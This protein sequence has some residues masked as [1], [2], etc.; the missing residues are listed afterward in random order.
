MSDED[1]DYGSG[2][3]E[4]TTGDE[5]ETNEHTEEHG[6]YE[7]IPK[8]AVPK[9]NL[10]RGALDSPGGERAQSPTSPAPAPNQS[11]AR[12]SYAGPG[13]RPATGTTSR[14]VELPQAPVLTDAQHASARK[15]LAAGIRKLKTKTVI[16]ESTPYDE[17]FTMNALSLA[18]LFNMG[19]GAYAGKKVGIAQTNEDARDEECQTEPVETRACGGQ[20]PE[21]RNGGEGGSTLAAETEDMPLTAATAIITQMEPGLEL[22]MNAFVMWAGPIVLAALGVAPNS[23]RVV[24]NSNPSDGGLSNGLLALVYSDLLANRPVSSVAFAAGAGA[25]PLLLAAYGPVGAQLG[26]EALLKD[27]S[28]ATK[29]LLCVWDLSAPAT[30]RAILVSEGSPTCCGFAPSPASHV[31]YAGMEEGGLCLW[32]LEEPASRHQEDF[33]GLVPIVC[34]RPSYTTEHLAEMNTSGSPIV[35]VITVPR[36]GSRNNPCYMYSLSAFG[37]VAVWTLSILGR[38]EASGGGG[39]AHDTDVDLGMRIGSSVRLIRLATNVRLGLSAL[40][41]LDPTE[42]IKGLDSTVQ[43]SAIQALPQNPRHFLVAGDAGRILKG[44]WAGLAPPPKELV[45]HDHLSAAV[46]DGTGRMR[47]PSRVT[48]LHVSPFCAWGVLSGHDDGTI[49]LHGVASAT[50]S[51]VWPAAV[52]GAV[53]A[54]RWSPARPCVFLV[55]DALCTVHVFDLVKSRS[56]P[57][58][59]QSFMAAGGAGGAASLA[60]CLE[61]GVLPQP[62]TSGGGH[63]QLPGFAVGYD[64]GRVDFMTFA[65]GLLSEKGSTA[66]EAR[67]LELIVGPPP[68]VLGPPSGQGSKAA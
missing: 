27:H 36:G 45:A 52:G 46:L 30:P 41:H 16:L 62:E 48:A 68:V 35:S 44:S 22:K 64:D 1:D 10:G 11:R 18:D 47:V 24:V 32:D 17:I 53:L 25:E 51:L 20:A 21:D 65:G 37:N 2:F 7:V 31:V 59:S 40:K 38:Q 9:S 50:A 23:K 5:L 55:L 12:N 14:M 49:A 43:S 56:A 8:A 66:E 61:V 4:Y 19:R 67:E 6:D 33:L 28:L 29:G 58:H 13:A 39:G 63:E 57:V 54:A 60:T 34:R 42:E 15:K 26:S 3:E